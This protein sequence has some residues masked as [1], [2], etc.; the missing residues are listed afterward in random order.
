[1]ARRFVA[2]SAGGGAFCTS[3]ER[4]LLGLGN[5]GFEAGCDFEGWIVFDEGVSVIFLLRGC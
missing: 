5:V 3:V 2:F 4:S 1:M